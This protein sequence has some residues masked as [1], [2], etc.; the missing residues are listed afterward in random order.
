MAREQDDFRVSPHPEPHHA[1]TRAIL[2]AHPEV[3]E[4][5]GRNPWSFAIIVAGVGIQLTLAR[6]LAGAPWWGLVATAWLFGAFVNH[7]M[8]VMIHEATHDLILPRRWQNRMA[9]ILADTIN[10]VPASVSFRSYHLKHHVHQGVYDLDADLPS[11]WEARLIGS[12]PPGKALWLLFFPL[13]Q[14]TRPPRL[15]AI[16]FLT[17]WTVVN[18]AVALAADVAVYT[19]WGPGALAYL[20]ASFF[21][22]V[23][24]HPLGARWIQEHYLTDDPQETYSYYG[25]ANRVAM[26]VGYHNEHHDFPSVPWSRLPR[27][28]AMAPEFYEDRE[29]H[30]SWTGLLLRFVFDRELSLFSRMTRESREGA[31][32]GG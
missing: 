3:R 5:I 30:G 26:N 13:F 24:L 29:Y 16:R 19:L 7:A 15:R 18:W 27:I 28:K 6:L 12:G 32:E 1:R 20:L 21:F 8:Y 11:R 23:G 17:A 9:G 31:V 14:V 4:L 25:G 10:V 2:R 22:S